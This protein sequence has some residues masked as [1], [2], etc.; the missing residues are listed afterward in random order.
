MENAS[1]AY[2]DL[3]DNPR[4]SR[5]F[6]ARLDVYFDG[7]GSPP[8]TLSTNVIRDYT[9]TRETA[10]EDTFPLG[11]V[12]SNILT[13][14]LSNTD[15][16]FTPSNSSSPFY[17]KLKPGTK[18]V[19]FTS[20]EIAPSIFEE[21]QM[22]VMYTDEWDT[23]SS[24][25]FTALTCYDR[26]YFLNKKPLPN[27]PVFENTTIKELFTYLF[28]V[29]G[30][31]SSEYD[32]DDEL[33]RPVP[34]G[35]I[36]GETVQDAL[37]ELSIAGMCTVYVDRYDKIVVTVPYK[38][39]TPGRV[40]SGSIESNGQV[41]FI[42]Q[43]Q[44]AYKTY[45]G[46]DLEYYSYNKVENKLLF[47]LSNQTIETGPNDFK[48]IKYAASPVLH[49]TG[50]KI[51]DMPTDIKSLDIGAASMDMSIDSPGE[52]TGV[53]IAAYGTALEATKQTVSVS[54]VD[55][56]ERPQKKRLSVSSQLLQL[57]SVANT[58]ATAINGIV[59]DP[60]AYLTASLRGDLTFDIG[61]VY[62]IDDE[63]SS[64]DMLPVYLTRITLVFNGAISCE[65]ACTNYNTLIS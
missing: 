25:I 35:W 60:D 28:T 31:S 64:I 48:S 53:R 8:A 4:K 51:D 34:F 40:L 11:R 29:L 45:T 1:Q 39:K 59:T 6:T 50:I 16:R 49:V 15:K 43:Q 47:T 56:D 26:I 22:G 54:A 57:K 65:V 10:A 17:K 41:K 38:D 55:E 63:R 44:S 61:D 32:I 18:C 42:S 62:F 13:V 27:L 3:L 33:D 37:V 23:K 19:L 52:Q 2:F 24:D 46:I 5:H 36:P 7:P 30:L 21:I 12:S 14:N 58:Y 20:L 9:Y